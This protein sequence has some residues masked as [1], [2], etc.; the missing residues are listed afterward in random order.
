MTPY[1]FDVLQGASYRIDP[2][3]PVGNRVRELRF[4]GRD[5]RE[6]DLFSLAV[7]SYRAQGSGGYTALKGTKVLRTYNDE[8]RELLVERLRKAGTIQP[9]T[10]RN[11]V[12]AP[13]TIWA[14]VALPVPAPVPAA[15][16]ASR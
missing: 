7:N 12:L 1:N 3:A 14:P 9:V 10:D 2:A 4:K 16:A 13:E 11:W 8:V 15:P 5:V 6:S